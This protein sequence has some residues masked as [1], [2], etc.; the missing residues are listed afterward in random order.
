MLMRILITG[1]GG[2]IGS[3][4]VDRCVADGHWVMGLDRKPKKD[5]IL[6]H[7]SCAEKLVVDVSE[8]ESLL[9][10]FDNRSFDLCYHLAA[11]SRIQPSFGNPIGYVLSNMLGTANVLELCYKQKA[12]VVYAGSSTADDDTAKNVYATTKHQGEELC[13]VWSKCFDVYAAVARFYNVYGP[14]Q[15]EDGEY[16][17]VI[18]IWERQLRQGKPL[19]VTGDGSQRRDFTHVTDIVDGLVRIADRIVPVIPFSFYNL[20]SGENHS[21]LE[22][23]RMFVEDACIQYIPRPPGE[24]E[25]TLADTKKTTKDIGWLPKHRLEDYVAGVL[26]KMKEGG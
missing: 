6:G 4:L 10:T 14:R 23:A 5:W 7:H 3:H 1:V 22:V 8:L 26:E 13:R 25:V 21:L 18:G 15:L 17:T 24:S 11:E 2:F 16:A 20:G 12:M 19:T 9:V